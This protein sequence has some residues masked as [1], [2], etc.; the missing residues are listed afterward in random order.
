VLGL[1]SWRF[2]GERAD[3]LESP[4]PVA[5]RAQTL[6][7]EST[8]A[9]PSRPGESFLEAFGTKAEGD[10]EPTGPVLS[11]E[12]LEKRF[13]ELLSVE[14]R[15]RRLGEQVGVQSEV[16]KKELEQAIAQQEKLMA[17]LNQGLAA[18]EK[19]L[20]R[21][22]KER[23]EAAI[24]A[25]LTGELLIMI[26]G[27]PEEILPHLQ[28]ALAAGL[29]R[30]RLY[31]SLARAQV[32]AN[33]FDEAFRSAVRG[34]ERAPADRQAWDVFVRIA[35]NTQRFA[36]VV[37]RIDKAYPATKP[38]WAVEVR[39]E[40]TARLAD[41]Q[42]EEKRRQA[43]T[44]ADDLPRVRLVVEHRRF[45]R[46][47]RG[48]ATTR[49]E[50]SGKGEIIVELFEDQA[51]AAV[52][53]FLTLV[54]Q[55]KYDGTRFYL[56]EAA[57][58]VAGGDVQSKSA[59]PK[60]DGRGNPGYFIRDEFERKDARSHYRG[61]LSL[62]NSGPNTSGSQFFITLVPMPEMD[63][64][65]TVFGRVIQGQDVVDRITRGR[66]NLEVGRYGRI[67]PGDLLVQAEVLRKRAHEYRLQKAE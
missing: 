52:A 26:R 60:E 20:G 24:P 9:P 12:A 64:Q 31:T 67:I 40:A 49:V 59:D 10:Q 4:A 32:E 42:A 53:N 57:T 14:D 43:E 35:F 61:S 39:G 21:A 28:R 30:P 15:L 46:D 65:F 6:P 50:S 48:T 27:E 19:E 1:A 41:W 2:V 23:P 7:T 5:D 3:D 18:F 34:L 33:Q 45:A 66:T 17:Q 63:G 62:V 55:K 51:P 37:S 13:Q 36:E 47:E 16:K 58:L 56:A 22:R 44:R 29:D 11:D 38:D 25:W 54:D 8:E